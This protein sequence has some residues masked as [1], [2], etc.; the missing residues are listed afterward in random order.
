M[1]LI[2]SATVRRSTSRADPFSLASATRQIIDKVC[3][4]N[5]SRSRAFSCTISAGMLRDFSIASR[6]CQRQ[7]RIRLMSHGRFEKRQCLVNQKVL[8]G[9]PRLHDRTPR[10]HCLTSNSTREVHIW[11]PLVQPLDLNPR[12]LAASLPT[13]VII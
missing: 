5:G 8:L 2:S 12:M 10:S 3:S 4:T 6:L 9:F 11:R 13:H 7:R 1:R